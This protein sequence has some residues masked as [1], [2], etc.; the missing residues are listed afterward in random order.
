MASGEVIVQLIKPKCFL[1]IYYAL[2]A[3]CPLRVSQF[4]FIKL[5]HSPRSE[6]VDRRIFRNALFSAC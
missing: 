4:K 5:R 2:E 6:F 3:A 1:A